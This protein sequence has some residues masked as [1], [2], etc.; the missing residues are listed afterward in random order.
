MK[1]KNKKMITVP[2][3][4]VIKQRINIFKNWI[5][6]LVLLEIFSSK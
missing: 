6:I 3:I 5:E 4:P 2:K 1:V